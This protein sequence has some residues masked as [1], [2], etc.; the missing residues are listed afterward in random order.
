MASNL[1]FPA[2][3]FLRQFLNLS[4]DFDVQFLTTDFQLLICRKSEVGSKKL[5]IIYFQ[6]LTSYFRLPTSEFQFLTFDFQL[7]TFTYDFQHE[8]L[9]VRS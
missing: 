2:S 8:K 7:L 4:S 6:L 3:Y 9:E 5:E 1:L